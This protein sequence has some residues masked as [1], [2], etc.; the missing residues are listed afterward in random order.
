MKKEKNRAKKRKML[1]SVV[2]SLATVALLIGMTTVFGLTEGVTIEDIDK[3]AQA[4]TTSG[5]AISSASALSSALRGGSSSY[6]LSS[7]I[8]WTGAGYNNNNTFS[9]TLYGNGKTITVSSGHTSRTSLPDNSN[10]G[11]FCSVLTGTIRDCTIVVNDAT[12][13]YNYTGSGTSYTS[14]CGVVCGLLN[15]GKLYNVT[16]KIANN[17]GLA[18]FGDDTSGNNGG[19]GCML[20]AFAGQSQGSCTIKNCTVENNGGLWVR[21]EDQDGNNNES[22]ST[23]G[24]CGGF[25]GEVQSGT[26]SM[27]NIRLTGSS[28]GIIG[29]GLESSDSDHKSGRC[30][31]IVGAVRSGTTL[32][33]NGLLY[34]YGGY[35]QTYRQYSEK[36]GLVC[37]YSFG[38]T[39]VSNVY[40]R[41][42]I[43]TYLQEGK[44]SNYPEVA[45]SSSTSSMNTANDG[46]TKRSGAMA[47][48]G[49]NAG[50]NVTV[51]GVS[52]TYSPYPAF[53]SKSVSSSYGSFSLKPND[54]DTTGSWTFT[55]K[56]ASGYVPYSCNAA[57][58]NQANSTTSGGSYSSTVSSTAS[59]ITGY[60]GARVTL[61]GQSASSAG[62]TAITCVYGYAHPSI[63]VPSRTGY[64]FGG[65]YTSTGGGGTQYINSSGGSATNYAQSAGCTLYAK[66][67]AITYTVA[68][69]TNGGNGG[70][71][72]S[73]THTYDVAK[74][75]TSNGFT[76]TGYSFAGWATSASGSVTYNNSA[77]VT[78]LSST[79][80]ATVN[81]YAKWTANSYTVTFD[82]QSASTAG[83]TSATATYD[84]ACP[85]INVP[86][87]VGYTF[88]GYYTA[89]GGGGTQ[90]YTATGS[91]A[92]N[93]AVAGS[94]TLYAKW[95]V[96]SYTVTYNSNG[97]S[98][99]S[100]VTTNYGAAYTAPTPTRT[101]Y[102]FSGWTLLPSGYTPVEY[103]QATGTQ[104][105][106][107]GINPS[108]KTKIT[109]DANLTSAYSIF[110][111]QKSGGS[112]FNNTGS[113][114]N[115]YFYWG[116][117][118]NF[119]T[120]QRNG[121]T[122]YTLD[123]AGKGYK[124]GVLWGTSSVA[125]TTWS[126][127]LPIYLFARNSDGSINDAGTVTIYSACIW[128]DST[129]KRAY[130]PC[131]NSSG[132][133]GMYDTVEGKFYTNGGSGS[134]T[135]GGAVT[136]SIT[137]SV[138]LSFTGVVQKLYAN[139]T[140]NTYT[141]TLNNQLA[142]NIGSTSVQA[143]YDSNM[144]SITAPTRTGY[145]FG[146]Y[147]SGYNNGN[148]QYY[149]SAGSSARTWNIAANTTLY[150]KWIENPYYI[151]FDPN[152]G[153]SVSGTRYIRT[154]QD[155]NNANHINHWVEV[156]AFNV[157]GT[158]VAAKANN[159]NVK[160]SL[161]NGSTYTAA[162][163]DTGNYALLV[164][165]VKT[166]S[167]YYG[168][169]SSA[170]A[171]II[172][173]GALYDVKSVVV[174]PY[175][176][177]NRIY[178]DTRTE[179]SADGVNW[180][181]VYDSG[182]TVYGT[183][184][185]RS[186]GSNTGIPATV[187]KDSTTPQQ[188][189][190]VGT[191]EKLRKNIV[192]RAGYTFLGWSTSS[193]ATS[194][195]YTDGQAVTNL[196]SAGASVTLYA[197]WEANTVTVTY[198]AQGGDVN[199]T[200]F[201]PAF[202][203]TYGTLAT[204]TRMGYT[205][206]GWSILPSG[207]TQLEYIQ[208][209]GAQYLDT[210]FKPNNNTSIQ[211]SA[212]IAANLSSNQCFWC[213][214]GSTTSTATW[215][216]FNI[217]GKY[218]FDY[219]NATGSNLGTIT[220][221]AKLKLNADGNRFYANNA[222]IATYNQA[223]FTG[224]GDIWLAASYSPEGS[225]IGNYSY[226]KFYSCAV[227]DNGTL[228]RAYV[229]CKN[230]SGTVGMYDLVNKT[231]TSSGSTAFTAG[232]TAYVTSATVM[233]FPIAHT[234]YARWTANAYT[235]TYNY[236]KATGSNTTTSESVT[237]N[238]T[239]GTLVTPTRTG[240][241]FDG[242]K[243][244]PKEYQQVE[245]INNTG[246]AYINTGITVDSTISVYAD[247][248]ASAS[249][250][251]LYGVRSAGGAANTFGVYLNSATEY[252]AQIGGNTDANGGKFATA[253]VT[254]R[255]ALYVTGTTADMDG[256]TKLRFNNT[257]T[258]YTGANLILFSM[259]EAGTVDTRY[260]TG[261]LYGCTI[262]KNG[263]AVRCFVPCYR[264]SDGKVGLYDLVTNAFFT[265]ATSVNFAKGSDVTAFTASSST[266]SYPASLTL[267]AIW[268]LNAPTFSAN[269]G[270]VSKVY[271]GSDSTLS[272]T[273]SHPAL[274]SS[275]VTYAWKKGDSV[276][277]GKTAS[278]LAVKTVADSGTYVLTATLTND[279]QSKSVSCNFTVSITKATYNMTN[280]KWNYTSAF[281]YDGTAKTVSVTG[282][283]T[284]VTVASYQNNQATAA[285]GYTAAVTLSYDSANYNA[286]SLANLS[287]TISKAN[288]DM[289]GVSIEDKAFV[290]DGRSHNV[291]VT[292]TLPTGR[293][294]IQVTVSYSGSATNVSEGRT[295]VTANFAT[296]STN[297]NVPASMTAY[298]MI[299]PREITV[300]WANDN[301]TY[302]GSNQKSSV[303]ATYRD[304]SN[305]AVDMLTDLVE[306][307]DYKEDGYLVTASFK[308]NETNYYLPDD[309]TKTF[310]IKK[311]A[312]DDATIT[313]GAS[314][315]YNGTEQT[316]AIK[317][318]YV[319]GL[320]VTYIAADNKQTNAGTYT[321]TIIASGNFTG[322]LTADYS[323]A[324]ANYDMSGITFA[325]VTC[326]FDDEEHTIIIGGTLPTGQDGKQ[327]TVSYTGKAT[328]VVQTPLTVTATFN[329]T[330]GNY[331]VPASKQ[332]TLTITPKQVAIT[333]SEDDFTYNGLD[334]SA[335]VTASYRDI[336][337]AIVPL[338]V[339][340]GELKDYASIG[341]TASA[342]FAG[343]ETNYVLPV[344]LTKTY[345][346]KRKSVEGATFDLAE[347]LSYNSSLQ[348]QKITAVTVD[349]LN[350]TYAI[351]GNTGKDAGDYTM[352]L[353]ANGNFEGELV[354]D[355]SI[356]TV[357]LTVTA[358]SNTITY[359]Q[360]PAH[361]GV[362][363]TG[364]QGIE[365]T[366]YLGG[367]LVYTFD[368][369]RYGDVGD[370]EIGIGGYTSINYDITYI[371]GILTV[372][373][374][375]INVNITPGVGSTFGNVIPAV[376]EF[377]GNCILNDDDVPI[378][379]TYLGIEPTVYEESTVL[380]ENAGTYR[381]YARI[382]TETSPSK[383]YFLPLVQAEFVVSRADMEIST[384]QFNDRTYFY[385]GNPKSVNVE[386]VPTGVTTRY[387]D[388][389]NVQT[390]AGS[391]IVTVYFTVDENFNPIAPMT[392]KL[393]INKQNIQDAQITLG[394]TV[395]YNGQTQQQT[396]L[397]V[398]VNGIYATY[399]AT[400]NEQKEVGVYRMT[401]T[402]TGNF[403]GSQELTWE[404][405]RR[406][407][408][409]IANDVTIEYGDE[410]RDGGITYEGFAEGQN[411]DDLDGEL[412]VTVNYARMQDIGVYDI[413]VAGFTS[414]SYAIQFVSG[415]IV[416]TKRNI[417][418]A[419]IIFG[420][421]L[422]YNG[423][424]QTQTILAV[425][426]GGMDVT[427][428][429]QNDTQ[430]T[431]GTY[432]MVL[433][434]TGNFQGTANKEWK[435]EKAV[436]DMSG[437]TMEE[438][439]FVYD[440]EAHTL[441]V[442]GTFPVGIDGVS[443]YVLGY[444]GSATNVGEGR[445]EVSAIFA[446]LSPN[447]FVP[448]TIKNYVS[449][450][451]LPVS[452]VWAPDDFTYNRTDQ[453]SGVTAYFYDIHNE[454][455][456]LDIV[457]REFK[458]YDEDGYDA[459]AVIS[460]SNLN[461]TLDEATETYHYFM[462]KRSIS[463]SS[464]EYG[465]TLYYSGKE[466][467]QTVV[468]VLVDG[469]PSTFR[470][471]NN[472]GMNAG[473]YMLKAYGTENY[474]GSQSFEFE[475]KKR[476]LK[477]T[478]NNSKVF[479][480][481]DPAN[482]GV[483]YEGFVNNETENVLSGTLNYL[484]TYAKG[485]NADYYYIY[486]SG[487]TT[488][489]Y[490]ITWNAGILEVAKRPIQLI[491][492]ETDLVYNGSVQTP[493][494]YA[495][496][497]YEGDVCI[498]TV[499]GGAT[500]ASL[501]PYLAVVEE[502]DHRNYCLP[503][504]NTKAFF[505]SR[506]VVAM[507]TTTTMTYTYSGEEQH[508][509]FE[510]AGDEELYFLSGNT[511]TKSG[512]QTVTAYLIDKSN[513]QWSDG[514]LS[515]LT[516]QFDIA[517]YGVE[518]PVVSSKPYTGLYQE[519]DLDFSGDIYE[520]TVCEGGIFAG[521]Y[522]VEFM[523]IDTDNYYWEEADGQ[524][525]LQ[526]TFVV[527][528]AQNV[529][530]SLPTITDRMFGQES[531]PGTA[532]TRFGTVE[533]TYR[534][535]EGTD[536]DYSF[537]IPYL[538]GNY[539]ARFFV[540][541]SH[542]YEAIEYVASFNIVKATYNMQKVKWNYVSEF[543]FDGIKK[544][545]V[546]TGL[547]EGVTAVLQGNEETN[548]GTYEATA[549]LD[550]D[551]ENYNE[552]SVAPLVWKISAR[553][554]DVVWVTEQKYVYTGEA[555][556]YPVAYFIDV[557]ET[558]KAL[559][560]VLP[561]GDLFVVAGTHT[562]TAVNEDENYRLN[563]ITKTRV[564][565]VEKMAITV[566]SE[567]KTAHFCTGEEQTYVVADSVRYSVSGNKRTEHG[568][569]EVTIT[570]IDKDNTVWADGTSDDVVY[571]FV[572]EHSFADE[573]VDE[574]HL[575][576]AATCTEKAVYFRAC[577]CGET[578]D[579]EYGDPLGHTYKVEFEWTENFEAT[580]HVTCDRCDYHEDITPTMSLEV[581]DRRHVHKATLRIE[582]NIFTDLKE[583]GVVSYQNRTYLQPVW[584][585][586]RTD[587]TYE[588]EAEFVCFEDE[589][590]NF[591]YI[592]E[593]VS[594]KTEDGEILYT[595]IINFNGDTYNDEKIDRKPIL[596][597]D[598]ANGTDEVTVPYFLPDVTDGRDLLPALPERDGFRFI[599]W[600]SDTG[601]VI[602]YNENS[603]K[604]MPFQPSGQDEK[605]TALWKG[606]SVVTLSVVDQD[607]A[608]V[609]GASVKLQKGTSVI[610]NERTDN[611]GKTVLNEVLFDNYNA[612]IEYSNGKGKVTKSVSVEVDTGNMEQ[613]I[614]LILVSINTIIDA[615][616][617]VSSSNLEDVVAGEDK[618]LTDATI[619]VVMNVKETAEENKEI[620]EKEFKEKA[621]KTDEKNLYKQEF[622]DYFDF[623]FSQTTE[624]EQGKTT[625]T[626]SETEKSIEVVL[627]VS[628][629]LQNRMNERK[630]TLD[631]LFV[632][633]RHVEQN[634]DIIIEKLD[635]QEFATGDE[636]YYTKTVGASSFIVIN[637]KKF[638]TYT[639]GIQDTIARSLN[640]ILTLSIQNWVFGE[641][642]KVP[643]ATAAFG[644][645]KFLYGDSEDGA[646][647]EV[648]P[649]S[650]GKH[651]VKAYVEG[652]E[653]YTDASKV[654]GFTI[655]QKKYDMADV[656]FSD[657]KVVKDGNA[658]S[659]AVEGVLPEGVSVTYENN[660]QTEAGVYLVTAHFI[661]N[662]P[663]FAPI[664]DMTATLTIV[665][666]ET[667]NKNNIILWCSIGAGVL[668]LVV[669]V[670][671]IARK[672]RKG[673]GF[674]YLHFHR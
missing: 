281:T 159:A 134:F 399:E 355:W 534:S 586:T 415:H 559:T 250:K 482:N 136:N 554:V 200:T 515:D 376:A 92:K 240:F 591:T 359:G 321:L 237:Y 461:Y 505:I 670:I 506:A 551:K 642:A 77:S 380:P 452:A 524:Q 389:N 169:A 314:L 595:A 146:G 257:L 527:S 267:N 270:N 90:Y 174:Y 617:N 391:Y 48:G 476:E 561:E 165:G 269:S 5:T 208:S 323:I 430:T 223:S 31:G 555:I 107:T 264:K 42:D 451:P 285:G 478:A 52:T 390:E 513:Y 663:N 648:V 89:S 80:G 557:D 2:L 95:T 49:N 9:G 464:I 422:T 353:T 249:G 440:G 301:F 664:P 398:L 242:W 139:W 131:K 502:L 624:S 135:A 623:D 639:L 396:I 501:D 408:R 274:A 640:S 504:D 106:N 196:A 278:T 40:V 268:T 632:Y 98:A 16:I 433:T 454:K 333:W 596:T 316:Q 41:S 339:T 44:S 615:E 652:T 50:T 73:S 579:Y 522:P 384:I 377:D 154:W 490:T 619:T 471:E 346:V 458:N 488:V 217:G 627:P 219:A 229:P 448:E 387:G 337:N 305:K 459:V 309:V 660:G 643:Q 566:P 375:E 481:D 148:T 601:A 356:A 613:T 168:G 221:D 20:G 74:N 649:S 170:Q 226:I 36:A 43:T 39:T 62:T 568:S 123:S 176:A 531:T 160:V 592:A 335:S 294:G 455:R 209:A 22:T 425:T 239:Y 414:S 525:Y 195:T 378:I 191:S 245:Y 492:G 429:V 625:K 79:K 140:A 656:Y 528:K 187:N 142:T 138:Q 130:V 156:E 108:N 576:K 598:L 400:G 647:S 654:F 252:W 558:E 547:P 526:K 297:Y 405:K 564:V 662:N 295:A 485:Q 262:F 421:P 308:N 540:P 669:I 65:Y 597:F 277:S 395:I 411:T 499:S 491:W 244:L 562:F 368:Y 363:Y 533:V 581:M 503:S 633:R 122:V 111:C 444:E 147:Y 88:G 99:V 583:E 137:S 232:P 283:P 243:L 516:F 460:A 162:A 472:T 124:N 611:D 69:N 418:S 577:A 650:A 55:V 193:T 101:G 388:I 126:I 173:L 486:P 618:K 129:L 248:K 292:G 256:A 413:L 71:T 328:N 171:I 457:M 66:W 386:G 407:L 332:A 75:L 260:F 325:D 636:F 536:E 179:V 473:K 327:V 34:E 181:V 228:V 567:N 571:M 496:D 487:L 288:Y 299:T 334:Q 412:E 450:T 263:T 544:T 600:E 365:D 56:A 621:K 495:G 145:T 590:Y 364:F 215:T 152:G 291:S 518:T 541:S 194:A 629:Q 150:A 53:G 671:I 212:A 25:I 427:Y 54:N 645:V 517:R 417:G 466:Q 303:T 272:A 397:A 319:D 102:T 87:K 331:N 118:G 11:I 201:A 543:V 546:L 382:S 578:E 599:G 584:N 96:N 60:V 186:Y 410:P 29:V 255:T 167:P 521:E 456:W 661:G 341:Y 371:P 361:A 511:R 606:V 320:P 350:V 57:N 59:S 594:Q 582:S 437:I 462:K 128:E 381:I 373:R 620:V 622:V 17:K 497:L 27:Y 253:A 93:W 265:T 575:R 362:Y 608:P 573:S 91:S 184:G 674:N 535:Q 67:T 607:N 120:S 404:V 340:I 351:V 445:V 463:G 402:G 132:T 85:T 286:P 569:Q 438:K 113:G 658:Y 530:T 72:A 58:T 127:D 304:V 545:V 104:F 403:T 204:P 667:I 610:A 550:Y 602:T 51:S 401:V 342:S 324:K 222:L 84:S 166:S 164:D 188:K 532:T 26:T 666:Q 537:E 246:A 500:D 519:A 38:T 374:K 614:Q 161:N 612:I 109:V 603:E 542:D 358:Y 326:E 175:F 336:H 18:F 225:G 311:K 211:M 560:V 216:L 258:S 563:D 271:N 81:L 484:Y 436:Y 651:Y 310:H 475:I 28:T 155:G 177:D 443:P 366:S 523:L 307:K 369:E 76:K 379:I 198:D 207:Y 426:S 35:I 409:I 280:A 585:W 293:D 203:A 3:P 12:Y 638:S 565:T 349:G 474:E 626:I 580:A 442:E 493:F 30:G 514:T 251:W 343:G 149:T 322:V 1:L 657:K 393:T 287:W 158:N 100:N 178:Y 570:L 509:I 189:C 205:F 110:G 125:G 345:H 329:T 392:A 347:V 21:A 180:S 182:S 63:T 259:N 254:N 6:Y 507:P 673:G 423:Q 604:Y 549:E 144:P 344:A 8:T 306:F 24:E 86:T 574:S 197:V 646:F 432:I 199:K 510:D 220:Q 441:C 653:E 282:L 227:W 644:T 261:N 394:P 83:A 296:A 553:L 659:L 45:Y 539:Y 637:A 302:N 143:T 94:T 428:T 112:K 470:L 47:S 641:I 235:V 213:A 298:V 273:V 157:A 548:A 668:V 233:E 133:L 247:F 508:Y 556:D 19:Y 153:T 15:G 70:S 275:T 114:S 465:A 424:P 236:D 431:A 284:G 588:A 317:S 434:G 172:D 315:T 312:I 357:P 589:A 419:S 23:R 116:T 630:A 266:V 494:V 313:L 318:V 616:V 103:L 529:W 449:V 360:A 416:V 115:D 538:V 634:G 117:G 631:N 300:T 605:L 61:D 489:N 183:Y 121:R 141:V 520:V 224:G 372:N 348:E 276:L 453:R 82:N 385:D 655:G 218:R 163:S 479:Y 593:V 97:G 609:K 4:Y 469:A 446:T 512:T 151:N 241:T 119:G 338:A 210:G 587:K 105:I 37:G 289:S 202:N 14:Y 467:T 279:G 435:I 192:S 420:E 665:A 10:A 7:D 552:I 290:F 78:N 383:N 68:Y 354:K 406:T 185:A 480:G 628:E 447:Y 439:A 468:S 190:L 483:T 370:F 238:S 477:I 46:Q 672:K 330:S 498:L 572:I 231:F 13:W 206:N 234:L 32:S 230:S 352:T 635:K 33:I 214:R 367:E 64:T